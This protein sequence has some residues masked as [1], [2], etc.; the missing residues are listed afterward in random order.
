MENRQGL[1]L[2]TDLLKQDYTHPQM[3][4]VRR[5]SIFFF[6]GLAFVFLLLHLWL[7]YT[8]TNVVLI[9]CMLVPQLLISIY[10]L[11]HPFSRVIGHLEVLVVFMAL[12]LHFIFNPVA[13]H[14]LVYWMVIVP[15]LSLFY[16]S[17]KSSYVWATIT[18]LTLM[19]NA[20][21]GIR[22]IGLN[23]SSDARYVNY[24]VVG[25]LMVLMVYV[26]YRYTYLLLGNYHLDLQKEKDE[27]FR[28]NRELNEI[29]QNME[30]EITARVEDIKQQNEK[31]ER[32]A[33]M[34]A[35]TVR[36]PLTNILGAARLILE[37]EDEEIDKTKLIELI[38]ENADDLDTAIQ[39]MAK[40]M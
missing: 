5:K 17:L 22:E 24:C 37:P 7:Q 34:N 14:A 20:W 8:G 6:A 26:L 25:I 2:Y 32:L 19:V 30:E 12:E 35:H 29:N 33:F 1:R 4:G 23:Y 27:V 36:A 9:L 10:L 11:R 31:L 3:M 38:G 28:L 15:I 21:Y 40:E 16:T 13:Y 18:C 39:K